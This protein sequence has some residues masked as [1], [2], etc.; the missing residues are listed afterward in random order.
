MFGNKFFNEIKGS[1]PLE[2]KLMKNV[3][4]EKELN[5]NVEDLDK[6]IVFEVKKEK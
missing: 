2:T 4:K 3:K 6:P 5:L 1:Q